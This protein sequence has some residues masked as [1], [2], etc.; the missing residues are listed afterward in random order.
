MIRSNQKLKSSSQE[1]KKKSEE[2]HH[3]GSAGQQ[4]DINCSERFF[5]KSTHPPNIGAIVH[6]HGYP[7]KKGVQEYKKAGSVGYSTQKSAPK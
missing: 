2:V 1:K 4:V 6:V 5:I 3:R 7:D